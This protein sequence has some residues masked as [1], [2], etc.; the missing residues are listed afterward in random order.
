[1]SRARRRGRALPLRLWL[2][3]T[4]VAIVVGATAAGARGPI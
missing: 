1:M 3:L 4:V 2:V